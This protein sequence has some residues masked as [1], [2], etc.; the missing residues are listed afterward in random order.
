VLKNEGIR[1]SYID[2][3]E[4]LARFKK[5]L[6][7]RDAHHNTEFAKTVEDGKAGIPCFLVDDE[8]LYVGLPEDLD[9][10]R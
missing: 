5:F 6:N 1:Y 4:D 10:L 8:F 2:V 3:L 7:L 9:L